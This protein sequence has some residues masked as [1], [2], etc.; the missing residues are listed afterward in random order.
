MDSTTSINKVIMDILKKIDELR[1]LH[2]DKG[3]SVA[4]LKQ[5]MKE[6]RKKIS[7]YETILKHAEEIE[8]L[9]EEKEKV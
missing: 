5:E 7:K 6:I 4:I 8:S 2:D 3:D 1:K 9:P